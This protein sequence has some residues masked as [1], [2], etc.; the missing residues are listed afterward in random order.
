MTTGALLEVTIGARELVVSRLVVTV[1]VATGSTAG[2]LMTE[3]TP[4]AGE[5]DDKAGSTEGVTTPGS[6][7]R[8]LPKRVGG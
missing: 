1:D 3:G 2:V 8:S 5:V 4:T 7:L 6:C